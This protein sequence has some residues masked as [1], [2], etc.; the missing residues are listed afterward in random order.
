[1]AIEIHYLN[2]E[3]LVDVFTIVKSMISKAMGFQGV[4]TGGNGAAYTATV[5]GITELKAGAT[6]MMVP[7]TVSTSTTA[8]LNVNNL[9]A[10]AIR[11]RVS[12]STT[13]T[14]AP[15]T[16]GWLAAKKPIRV[17]YDGSY[18]IADHIRPNANDIYGTIPIANGGTGATT[19]ADA[20]TKLGA[21]AKHTTVTVT[22]PAS[23]WSGNKQTVTAKNVTASNTVIA[24][25]APASHAVYAE[26][27][28]Y[29][30]AQA[31]GKLTFTCDYVPSTDITVNVALLS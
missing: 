23:G 25:P 28:V 3:G 10:K 11:R 2:F 7:H 26:N 17:T 5:K 6:F 18:W 20:L 31:A 13:T 19:A 1:M 4:T 16:A 24:S 21:Q 29:C 30:S 27:G 15:T 12:N 8:T 14:V 9:G 22:L